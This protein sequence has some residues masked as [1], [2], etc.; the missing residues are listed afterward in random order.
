MHGPRDG[1]GGKLLQ[2]QTGSAHA[3]RLPH[4]ST[5]CLQALEPLQAPRRRWRLLSV[6]GLS[7]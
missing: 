6:L 1:G 2:T 7:R 3:A 4:D 5:C